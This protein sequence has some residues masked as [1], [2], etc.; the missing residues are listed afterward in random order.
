M[1]SLK[2]EFNSTLMSFYRFARNYI[3]DIGDQTFLNGVLRNGKNDT[4][5]VEDFDALN[6]NKKKAL[7]EWI[8][9]YQNLPND[10]WLQSIGRIKPLSDEEIRRIVYSERARRAA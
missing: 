2:S 10:F 6:T 7:M 1:V 3:I 5:L 8:L 9:K 4:I